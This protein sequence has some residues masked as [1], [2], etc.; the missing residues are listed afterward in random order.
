LTHGIHSK[1]W[2]KTKKNTRKND[3]LGNGLAEEDGQME[4]V[5]WGF[6][7]EDWQS[8]LEERTARRASR[9]QPMDLPNGTL[10]VGNVRA[11]MGE[12]HKNKV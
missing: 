9:Q 4:G 5:D 1:R 7:V 2:R 12:W 8:A 3:L 11:G 6:T 10:G